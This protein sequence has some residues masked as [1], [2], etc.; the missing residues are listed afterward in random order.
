M[1]TPCSSTRCVLAL[2]VAIILMNALPLHG[3]N[4]QPMA[5]GYLPP[6]FQVF[7]ISALGDKIVWATASELIYFPPVPT[8]HRIRVLR[9]SDGGQTWALHQ[10]EEAQGTVSYQ[11]VALDSLT[12]WLTTQDLGSGPEKALYQTTDG[13][14]TWIKKNQDPG[15][16][17]GLT[18]FPDGQHWLAHNRNSISR[19]SDNALNW[20]SST[21][22]GYQAN[23]YQIIEAGSNM[24]GVAGDTLWNGT[25][26]GRII[27]FTDFGESYAFLFTGLGSNTLIKSIAFQDHL[28]GLL[29]SE[30]NDYTNRR[31]SRSTDGGTTWSQLP[32]QPDPDGIWNITAV[33][34]LPG[35]Y[36]LCS[37][38]LVLPQLSTPAHGKIALTANSGDTWTIQEFN[39]PFNA[40]VFANPSTGWVGSGRILSADQPAI[41]KY[42]GSPLVG[43]GGDP[44]PPQGF[45]V[46]P[47]P[48]TDRLYVQGNGA[49]SGPI[50]F[51][52][53]DLSGKIVL[54]AAGV[55]NAATVIDMSGL[56]AG[57]YLLWGRDDARLPGAQ[58]VVK[59]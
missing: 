15:L 41:L 29:F 33:P 26:T 46:W 40:V 2:Q 34:G 3:Q 50:H 12:A 19:S 59:Q 6:G 7:S 57:A 30:K 5:A 36:V 54:E 25:S 32:N 1:K 52:L 53:T 24:A 49:L 44:A 55:Y 48:V 27:R 35:F 56:P 17:V 4:W 39:Q 31:I 45:S 42:T 21:I 28:N 10:V 23:E 14:A 18:R 38:Y 16:G 47:N 11:I 20:N 58:K 9:S 43:T 13:G 8:N 22:T 51:Q 37:H